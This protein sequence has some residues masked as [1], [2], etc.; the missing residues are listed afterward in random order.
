VVALSAV[1]VGGGLTLAGSGAP[2][3]AGPSTVEAAVSSSL[4]SWG[5]P[6]TDRDRGGDNARGHGFVRDDGGY[7]PVDVRGASFTAAQGQNNAGHVVGGYIDG[8]DGQL[9]HHSWLLEGGRFTE[10]EP[11]GV[12]TGSLATDINDEGRI[13]GWLL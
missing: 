6:G 13:V 1:L 11:R 9:R 8:V 12:P 3:A 10:I 7:R 2:A 5:L 4:V